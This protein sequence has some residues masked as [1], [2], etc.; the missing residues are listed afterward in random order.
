M[1]LEGE[2]QRL[3]E[4]Q[5]QFKKPVCL[6]IR[7]GIMRKRKKVGGRHSGSVNRAVPS[8]SRRAVGPI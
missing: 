5:N 1:A 4:E 3:R 6:V 7:T 8:S 2:Y